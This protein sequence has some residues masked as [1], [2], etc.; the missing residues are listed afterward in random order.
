MRG[1]RVVQLLPLPSGD[2]SSDASVGLLSSD[3]R[4]KR[5]PIVE[6]QDLSSR[7]GSMLKLKGGV[8]LK[9]A[10]LCRKGD[11]LVAGSSA[12]RLLRLEVN[13]GK[14]PVMGRNAMGPV[15]LKLLPGETVIGAS[16][17]TAGSS[18]LLASRHGMVSRVPLEQIRRCKR[19][20]IGQI[21]IRFDQRDDE[22]IDLHEGQCSIFAAIL[23]DGRSQRIETKSLSAVAKNILLGTKAQLVGVSP[24]IY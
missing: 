5:V 11:D 6:F 14:L 12:G 20:D 9:R 16:T 3:G 4:F 8:P 22:L 24:L 17:G 7:A 13:E 1:E 15:L 10:V 18:L 2:N 19:G 23:C 21:G